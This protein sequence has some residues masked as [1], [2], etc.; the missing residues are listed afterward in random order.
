MTSVLLTNGL[1]LVAKELRRGSLLIEDG[2]I[3]A[4]DSAARADRVIDAGGAFVLPGLID[5]HTHGIGYEAI[6]ADSLHEFARIEA[7]CGATTFF[8]TL[9]HAPAKSMEHLRRHRANSNELCDLPNVG[10]FRL[11]SPYLARTG[12]GLSDELAPISEETTRA[13]LDAGGGHIKIWDLSPELPGAAQAIHW[14]SSQGVICSIAHTDATV[15]QAR[16]AVDAGAKLVTHLYD[17]FAP[18]PVT[19]PGVYPCGLVESLLLEDRVVCEIIG[20]GAHVHP[21]QV[22]LAFRCKTPERLAF[23]TDSNYGAGLPAGEYLLPGAWGRVAINGSNNGV[24]L[25]DRGLELAGSALTP[26]DAFRNAVRLFQQDIPTASQ[27]CATTPARLLGLNKGE[28]AVGRD[29]DLILLDADLEL[30]ATIAGGQ[31]FYAR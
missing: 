26:I 1:L 5:L 16:A 13:L 19:E 6:E 3:R 31:V 18:A 27:V 24:R 20:D 10:G 11:E 14:L 30:V 12:A 21:L 28:I 9:F 25:I 22:E 29:A 17:T 4:I 8:P 23:V 2:R 15:E 7:S